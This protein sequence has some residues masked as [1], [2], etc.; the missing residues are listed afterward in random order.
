MRTNG[1]IT[2]FKSYKIHVSLCEGWQLTWFLNKNCTGPCPLFML[3]LL[4]YHCTIP[5]CAILYYTVLQGY[6]VTIYDLGGSKSFRGIWP[7]YYHEVHGFIFVVDSA[8]RYRTMSWGSGT[9]AVWTIT[10]NGKNIFVAKNI[11]NFHGF[12]ATEM[13]LTSTYNTTT[14]QLLF[15]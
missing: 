8:D 10:K 13:V 12:Q 14:I 4:G 3:H 7:K 5:Y 2:R 6:H 9:V 15:I 1:R 11:C